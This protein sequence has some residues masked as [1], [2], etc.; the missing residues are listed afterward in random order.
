MLQA[1]LAHAGGIRID[2]VMGLKRLW[3]I[4]QGESADAG[5][6]LNYPSPI[7]CA[8]SPWNPGATARW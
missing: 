1:N 8:C 3:V 4:P 7:C 6:Y 2:H 5:A